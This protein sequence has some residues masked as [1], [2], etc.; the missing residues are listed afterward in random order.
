MESNNICEATTKVVEF[1]ESSLVKAKKAFK[2]NPENW[3]E[4]EISQH[5]GPNI[6]NYVR[7]Y[8]S[9]G[10]TGQDQLTQ[11]FKDNYQNKA[12]QEVYEELIEAE[13][14]WNKFLE[15]ADQALSSG[16]VSA[17]SEGEFIKDDNQLQSVSG[18]K[19]DLNDLFLTPEQQYVHFVL[20]RHFA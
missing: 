5:L 11:L 16:L 13:D 6:G 9:L 10:V 19:L 20:L 2:E 18:E 15:S 4:H 3:I 17:A 12:V 1:I 7:F 8:A 14:D